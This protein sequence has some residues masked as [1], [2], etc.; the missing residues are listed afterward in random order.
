MI[1]LIKSKF[2]TRGIILRKKKSS[3]SFLLRKRKLNHKEF[4]FYPGADGNLYALP[5]K[6]NRKM[7]VKLCYGWEEITLELYE[8]VQ[9]N[10]SVNQNIILTD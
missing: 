3:N 5:K 2:K 9:L 1:E 4:K 6:S 10:D 8:S 7:Y